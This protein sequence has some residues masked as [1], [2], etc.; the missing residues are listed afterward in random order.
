V[1]EGGRTG[2]TVVVAG[3]LFFL[4]AFF[5][6]V[7]Q[8]IGGGYIISNAQHYSLFVGFGAQIPTG[9]YYVYPITAGALIVVGYLM[10]GIVREITW[11]SFEAAFPAFLI[12][13]GIPLT[14]NI[15]YGIGFG[16]ISYTVLKMINGKFGEVHP[17]L[18]AVSIGF[19]FVFI[20]PYL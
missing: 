13:V 5:S 17:F 3:I 4:A 14:Y 9:N 18:Y 6:P 8:M 15:S 11:D 10:M 19:L 1:A 2:L 20:L 7:I 12:I 16:F